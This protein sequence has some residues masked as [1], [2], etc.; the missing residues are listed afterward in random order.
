[1]AQK[2]KIYIPDY[3]NKVEV[4]FDAW[5]DIFDGI[6]DISIFYVI[7]LKT[8]QELKDLTKKQNDAIHEEIEFYMENLDNFD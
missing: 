4:T 1:M 2:I 6:W 7:D 3:D 5:E 8:N